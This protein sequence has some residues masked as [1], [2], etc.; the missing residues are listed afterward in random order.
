MINVVNVDQAL[1]K[2]QKLIQ[3]RQVRIFYRTDCSLHS[4]QSRPDIRFLTFSALFSVSLVTLFTFT[5]V[6]TVRV[7]AVREGVTIIIS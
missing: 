3:Y 1:T 2:H 4:S 5:C 7:C 6:R